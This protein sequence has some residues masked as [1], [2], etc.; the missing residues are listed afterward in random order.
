MGLPAGGVM[1]VKLSDEED[2][3]AALAVARS[4]SDLLVV[5]ADGKAK[6]TSLAEYP[7]QGRYGQGVLT[8]RI[9]ASG[10]NLAGSCVCQ[11]RDPVVLVT[12]KGAA[13]TILARNAPRLG[14][15]TAG[16]SII[17][18]R[19]GDVVVDALVPLPRPEGGNGEEE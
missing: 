10:E 7:T 1:G 17:S 5:A 19:K 15:A 11:S 2:R 4:R 9:T 16:E 3:V 13:K 8:T 14:R 6:R 12:R 18:L